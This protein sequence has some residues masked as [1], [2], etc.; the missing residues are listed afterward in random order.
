MC[1]S[2]GGPP[3]AGQHTMN[4]NAE[5][6]RTAREEIREPVEGEES[7]PHTD[8]SLLSKPPPA[9]TQSHTASPPSSKQSVVDLRKLKREEL[10]CIKPS[11]NTV[12]PFAGLKIQDS[13]FL[14]QIDDRSNCDKCGKSR[15]YFCYTCYVPLRC[16]ASHVPSLQLPFKIDI[17]RHPREIAGKSTAVHA[18]LIC[19]EDVTIHTHPSLPDYSTQS[20]DVVLIFP[21]KGAMSV[22]EL[23]RPAQ[24]PA[25]K[26]PRPHLPFSKVVFIDC[27]WNQTRRIYC[28]ERVR[29]LRC[30][31]LNKHETL[32]WRYQR[33]KPKTY[34]ATIEAIYYF[35][36]EVYKATNTDTSYQGQ[37]DNLL[38][39]FKFM[40]EKIHSQYDTDL[41]RAYKDL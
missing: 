41:L 21:E 10:K 37:Y 40:Y 36:V 9:P 14:D 6:E 1:V 26:R 35:L 23:V 34:L 16:I 29:G 5:A 19:P 3:L 17:I 13:S 33:G 11:D 15:K 20:N 31:E 8:K 2:G 28:D 22:E 18:A 25:L 32:F 7:S 24:P 4:S 39:F 38:F 30:V 12:K 27:T